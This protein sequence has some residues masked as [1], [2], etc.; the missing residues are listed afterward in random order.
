MKQRILFVTT[1]Y[2]YFTL[3]VTQALR[4]LGYQVKIFDY[5]RPNFITRLAGLVGLEPYRLKL[6]NQALITAA[7]YY[8]PDYL[9]VIKGDTLFS[10][11]IDHINKLGV[12]TINWYPD[13]FD[14]WKWI[15]HHAPA[16]S[17]FINCCQETYRRLNQAGIKNYYLAFAAP[18]MKRRSK[19]KKIYPLT[20]IGQHTPRRELYF[21]PLAKLGLRIWGPRWENS[22]LRHLAHPPVSVAVTH[23][24]IQQSHLVVNILNGSDRHQPTAINIRTFETTALGTCLLVRADSLLPRYFKPNKELITF[25]SPRNLYQKAVYYLNHP[26]E[27]EKIALA[28]YNRI[29]KDHTFAKRLKQL[30]RIVTAAS[31]GQL[32]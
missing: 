1:D 5:Q 20:F 18:T 27:R 26:L 11:T 14:S 17:V 15:I 25:T 30:F 13:W 22:S 19:I 10:E 2:S 32:N 8:Q 6:I 12:I 23:E 9:L 29:L 31:N 24:I 16:Y 7:N 4:Q 28:G 21:Q 3:P